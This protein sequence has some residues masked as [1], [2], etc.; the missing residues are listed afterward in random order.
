[1]PKPSQTQIKKQLL[2]QAVEENLAVK[3]G[4]RPSPSRAPRAAA[5]GPPARRGVRWLVPLAVAGAVLGA[6]AAW[7]AHDLPL[8][9]S[10]ATPET[11]SRGPESPELVSA[12]LERVQAAADATAAI[13]RAFLA[14]EP[15]FDAPAI[16]DSDI[17]SLGIE[18]I[19]LDPGH[20]GADPGTVGHDLTEKEITL[21]VALRLR[22]LLVADGFTV[23]MTREDDTFL[24]LRERSERANAARADLFVSIH[25]NWIAERVTRGVETY[26][27]GSTS[28][29]ELSA[30]V[31]RENLNSGY[32]MTDMRGLLDGIFTK[33]RQ[34]ESQQ[35]ASRVQR[36]LYTSLL[37]E[38][39]EL[40]DRGVKTAPFVVLVGTEMPAI[41]AEV[42]CLSNRDEAEL[43][44]RPLYRDHIAKALAR[45]IR[46]YADE[47]QATEQKGI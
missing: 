45:G 22:D 38:N 23:E 1:M 43:L 27:L 29:P 31:R 33:M 5:S 35:L 17:L 13:D 30:I 32:T 40:V 37:H 47:V 15:R 4:R 18:H 8:A 41:L 25:V 9:T 11:V 42:S 14:H 20:G 3:D 46:R 12:D 21:D 39:P 44:A 7:S 24:S 36:S 34:K 28:D 10:S 6:F 2:R 19:I 16:I 26:F